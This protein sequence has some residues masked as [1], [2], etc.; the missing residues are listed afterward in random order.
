MS[1][2]EHINSASEDV[3]NGTE[4]VTLQMMNTCLT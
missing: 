1:K 3:N 2:S 4:K